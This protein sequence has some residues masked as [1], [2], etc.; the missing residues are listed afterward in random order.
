MERA[1]DFFHGKASKMYA[2]PN[3]K[4]MPFSNSGKPSKP[5]GKLDIS[6]SE[7][8]IKITWDFIA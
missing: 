7:N 3:A 1:T 8:P 4:S 5:I 6:G 2:T